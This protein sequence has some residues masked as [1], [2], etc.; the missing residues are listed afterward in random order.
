V[1]MRSALQVQRGLQLLAARGDLSPLSF[2]F[3]NTQVQEPD[4]LEERQNRQF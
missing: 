1:G 3:A 4:D 2:Q